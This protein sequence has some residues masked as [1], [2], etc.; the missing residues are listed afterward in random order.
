MRVLIFGD[1]ITQGMWDSQGGWAN[2]LMVDYFSQ[3]MKD[4]ESDVPVLF[5]LGISAD[6]TVE[7]LSRFDQE[8]KAR[9]RDEMVFVFAI[10]TNDARVD[11]QQPFSSP[12]Q[13]ATN[14]E[15][16][17]NKA[18]KFTTAGKVLFVGLQPCDETR[19][20]PCS[21]RD[22]SYFTQRLQQFD[23]A[24][25]K[26]CKQ[27]NVSFVPIYKA[28][29]ERQ[30]EQNILIDGLHPHDAGHQLLHDLVAPKLRELLR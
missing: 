6:T 15:A 8:T 11:G 4:L 28:F 2:R 9:L 26:V 29:Q 10:G 16:L 5:N 3:Q 25:E 18:K 22:T 30:A 14:V 24:L 7:L 13:Y 27:Q 12:E 20:V 21:W 19:T 1:S 23:A 17:I